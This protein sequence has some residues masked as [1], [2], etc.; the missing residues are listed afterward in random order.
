[1]RRLA[2]R[3]VGALAAVV[4]WPICRV[5]DAVDRALFVPDGSPDVPR[6]TPAMYDDLTRGLPADGRPTA[7]EIERLYHPEPTDG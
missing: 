2:A 3:A 6:L 7:A 5:A 1:M 4:L